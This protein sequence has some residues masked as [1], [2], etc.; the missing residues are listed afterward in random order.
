[1][2]LMQRM[3]V[4]FNGDDVEGVLATFDEDCTI[5]EPSEVPDTP[6]GGFR[7]HEG[8][9]SW[10]ANLRG[11][12]G[13]EFTVTSADAKGDVVFSEWTARGLGQSSGAPIAWTTFAVL[14]IRDGRI[15]RAEAFLREAEA[16][17]AAAPAE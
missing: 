10:M 12:G 17:D 2:A 15:L 14:Q 4:A 5:V 3:L 11:I 7:R 13:I 16:R 9:R 8:V 6:R 1:M